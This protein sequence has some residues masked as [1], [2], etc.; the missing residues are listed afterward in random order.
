MAKVYLGA[1]NSGFVA[2]N[3]NDEIIGT[4]G[5]QGIYINAGV[6][7]VKV[8]NT[9]ED[10]D[11]SGA[12]SEYQFR[13]QVNSTA[14]DVLDMQGRVLVTI[15]AASQ[16][17][18]F[19]D[20]T[21]QLSSFFGTNGPVVLLGGTQVTTA[22]ATVVPRTFDTSDLSSNAS[23]N[24]SGNKT[25]VFLDASDSRYVVS[26][27][28][29]A[30]TSQAGHQTL[31]INS[32]VTGISVPNTV[33]DID[34]AGV[35]EDFQF[36]QQPSST[37]VEV[38]DTNGDV[39]AE[40]SAVSQALSFFDGTAILG[41]SFTGGNLTV[42][43]GGSVISQAASS[44]VPSVFD[45]SDVSCITD[46]ND[47]TILGTEGDDVL[48]GTSG[49]DIIRGGRG[50]DEMHGGDGDDVFII[51]GDV[52]AGGKVD[53]EADTQALGF[54]LSSLNFQN[55][56]EDE[57]GAVETVI[58][59]AGEDT[60]YVIGTADISNYTI[61]G[62]EH[63][64]IRSDVTFDLEALDGTNSIRTINGDGSSVLRIDSGNSA[65]PV[66]VDLSSLTAAQLSGIDQID[67]GANV[68]LVIDSLN[69]LGDARVLT[70]LGKIK[71]KDA[72]TDLTLSNRYSIQSTLVIENSDGSAADTSFAV[73]VEQVVKGAGGTING[74][75][76]DEYLVG[77]AGNDVIFSG[78]GN[79]IMS[80][81]AGNDVYVINGEGQKVI[82][83]TDATYSIDR[84][85]FSNL[86]QGIV[87]DLSTGGQSGN[88]SVSLGL[89]NA[90]GTS[91]GTA[92]NLMMII[93]S[94]GSMWGTNMGEAKRAALELIE[95]YENLGDVAVRLIDFDSDATSEIGG[96]DAWLDA[97]TAKN[98]ISNIDNFRA[99]GTTSYYDALDVAMQAYSTN[100]NGNYFWQATNVS[101]FLSDGEPTIPIMDSL[102]ALWEQFSIDNQITSSAIGFDGVYSTAELEP[103]AFD[104]T[105]VTDTN[106]DGRIDLND[107]LTAAQIA[108]VIEVD[109]T[110]LADT[111][112]GQAQLDFIE[113]VI[114]TDFD[115]IFTGNSLNNTVDGGAGNDTMIMSGSANEYVISQQAN[116]Y[117]VTDSL[118][119]DG[120][121]TL[122]SVEQILFLD[123]LMQLTYSGS[124][125]EG[126][127]RQVNETVASVSDAGDLTLLGTVAFDSAFENA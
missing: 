22:A 126:E 27:D 23:T 121:N 74:T 127:G 43:L 56:N 110:K 103:V 105:K 122:E 7:G 57:D 54:N 66:V 9:V 113:N 32:G 92:V 111:I 21:S 49:N 34:F 36:R 119:R 72:D 124:G 10:I 75:D 68:E 104:G 26:N 83:D 99:S 123:Q 120:V 85:D 87:F 47:S 71:A 100:Q 79:D 107:D 89:T 62:I 38:L 112:L 14:I 117:V 28:D 116:V 30:I 125:G 102:Q 69:K 109:T 2:G 19:A 53:T 70:G 5:H 88:T 35:L 20:G 98:L 96:I 59:G 16:T 61:E 81:L 101:Y 91:S 84:I 48:V 6:T 37:I 60:L 50:V 115:D 1:S 80:G 42:T 24:S 12:I 82:V 94:S 108:P 58:G 65:T 15:T 40:I 13:Q 4:S 95:G 17:L 106:N 55:L 3:N 29:I 44:I 67:V 11:F 25:K 77:T 31:V 93:D 86:T 41:T 78:A 118:G 45:T 46:P 52:S 76:D 8:P 90:G 63:I 51:V 73:V 33:E 18:S 39:V 64:E 97:T 114:G